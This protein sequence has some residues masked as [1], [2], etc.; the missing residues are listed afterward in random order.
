MRTHQYRE[1]T[2]CIPVIRRYARALT[3]DM[4]R[5][6]DLVQ[7]CLERAWSRLHQFQQGSNMRA[8]L[9]TIMH[10]IYANQARRYN[11]TPQLVDIDTIADFP[12]S[13]SRQELNLELY[14]LEY[15]LQQ[16]PHEQREVL[17][18][19]GLE[20]MR[21]QEVSDII[22]IPVGTVMSRLYRARE[23][24]RNIM[25]GDNSIKVQGIND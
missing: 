15:A 11:K 8:W 6:D 13:N 25:E 7:D 20:G 14:D 12:C 1:L 24:L 22:G 3:N 21:Y 5:A 18:L 19:V 9:F 4:H 16:L 17:L 2:E 10:N 23:K